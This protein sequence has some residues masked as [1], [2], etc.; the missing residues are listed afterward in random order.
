MADIRQPGEQ[1]IQSAAQYLASATA[2]SLFLIILL[3]AARRNVSE[4]AA[5]QPAAQATSN[6]CSELSSAD[7]NPPA[8]LVVDDNPVN[9]MV[10]GEM[11]QQL[12]Y[13]VDTADSGRLCIRYCR[14]KPYNVIFM[15][16]NMPGM[17]GFSTT[18]ALRRLPKTRST[19]II[20]LTANTLSEH[21]DKCLE[22]GMNDYIAKPFNRKKLQSTLA[23]WVTP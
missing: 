17:D 3:I 8:L 9:R 5:I 21:K 11:L 14:E 10:A 4:K 18:E 20:A 19:P 6:A 15:D 16:C 23:R 7:N 12:G 22:A 13:Q 2:G 1:F